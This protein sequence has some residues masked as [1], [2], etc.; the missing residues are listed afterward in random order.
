MNVPTYQIG[1]IQEYREQAVLIPLF[2]G[3]SMENDYAQLSPPLQD[4]FPEDFGP[5]H[6]GFF[7]DTDS[8][9][10]VFTAV[11][12]GEGL[13]YTLVL[14]MA[15]E[16][17]RLIRQTKLQSIAIPIAAFNDLDESI[18]VQILIK[19]FLKTSPDVKLAFYIPDQFQFM[20]L[21]SKGISEETAVFITFAA[22]V[23]LSVKN[24]W[25]SELAL[26]SGFY[27][28]MA[29]DKFEEFNAFPLA[30]GV[31]TD[32][33]ADLEHN[34]PGRFNEFVDHYDS[35]S[36]HYKILVL[37]GELVAYIDRN[38]AN[39]NKW[40]LT[41]D[42]RTIAKA[43][44]RQKDW[45]YHLLR[46]R[47]TPDAIHSIPGNILSAI[48]YLQ[49][50]ERR[51]TMLSPQHRAML[52]EN[53]FDIRYTTENDLL[54]VFHIMEELGVHANNKENFGA[55]CSRIF[56]LQEIRLLWDK[57]TQTEYVDPEGAGE[58]IEIPFVART[59]QPTIIT[60]IYS[61]VDL[62]DYNLYAEAITAFIKHPSTVPPLTIGILAPWGK[63]KTTLMR[64]IK[65]KLA[66]KP[67]LNTEVPEQQRGADG[68]QPVSQIVSPVKTSYGQLI[69]WL[70]LKK[71]EM[72][73]VKKLDYPTVWFNAWKFQKNEQLWA[74]F[75]YEIIKQLVDQLASPLEKER[76]WLRLNLKRV[77]RDKL[78]KE[79]IF[80][81]INKIIPAVIAIVLAMLIGLFSFLSD[82]RWWAVMPVTALPLFFSFRWLVALL[83][84]FKSAQP[85]FDVSKYISQPE[86]KS[87]RGFLHDIEDDLKE[88]LELLVAENK[89]AVIFIDDLDRCSPTTVTQIVEAINLFISGDLPRCYFILGQDAQMVAAAL[90]AEYDKVGQKIT[91]IGNE[92]GSLGWHF[93]EKFIQLQ[94][95]IPVLNKEQS[96]SFLA[97]LLNLDLVEGNY[98]DPHVV[99]T[100][101]EIHEKITSTDDL[102]STL[103][104]ENDKIRAIEERD[105][106]TANALKETIVQKAAA[107]FND[108]DPEV[109]E[110]IASLSDYL[111]D[112]P[113][114][115]K[116][117]VNLYRF[118]RFLQFTRLNEKIEE[119][120]NIHLGQWITM[121]IRWPQLVRAIQ[122]DTE[123]FFTGQSPRERAEKFEALIGSYKD[124]AAWY[125][126]I[127]DIKEQN[128]LKDQELFIFLKYCEL[129][130]NT[131]SGAV[132][133][134][135]W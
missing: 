22:S 17:A 20:D 90:D 47:Y 36:K 117:F 130:N 84:R 85:D 60:D 31:L 14:T 93:M 54:P 28:Q 72:F 101:K 74:G 118:Y 111:G 46:F 123:D 8:G 127:T 116:R 124:H 107:T 50:P 44:V 81:G 119:S 34:W 82:I 68:T 134:G 86:Y 125:T 77:D 122:W 1:H 103:F 97:R 133:A 121:M 7:P 75:A 26:D 13:T 32:L 37:C 110:L 10:Y 12:K 132:D 45:V 112:S 120:N 78:K 104:R 9:R 56:Y 29:K 113:R 115:I 70:Q 105:P 62:L 95:N 5:G 15:E 131:L 94:F 89:N 2:P 96:K 4:M 25:I 91:N 98:Q 57:R 3:G 42:K 35:A 49:Q 135:I 52:C 19:V 40:N 51:L 65:K 108:N 100:A 21:D 106:L 83:K 30:S 59:V 18:C 67:V 64:F 61:S 16:L 99:T 33:F 23:G 69:D 129:E 87:K 63:G 80:K 6:V 38:A 73:E 55:L 109:R 11:T 48:L 126:Y 92:R 88:V 27:F 71:D 41:P 114:S 24:S 79:I 39:K 53:I 128:W 76:F 43:N 66:G 102:T 58:D